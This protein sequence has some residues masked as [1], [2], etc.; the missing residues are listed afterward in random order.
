MNVIRSI[1]LVGYTDT[2]NFSDLRS[3]K[4]LKELLE[5]ARQQ[6]ELERGPVEPDQSKCLIKL[7]NIVIKSKVFM[8]VLKLTVVLLFIN[9][10]M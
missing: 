4:E 3:S 1:C 7:L 9:L 2:I 6:E 10:K 8:S 5:V